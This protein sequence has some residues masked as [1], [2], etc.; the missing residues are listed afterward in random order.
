MC[1]PGKLLGDRG[2]V[3]TSVCWGDAERSHTN[4][5]AGAAEVL[6]CDRDQD[7]ARLGRYKLCSHSRGSGHLGLWRE[8]FGVRSGGCLVF[9]GLSCAAKNA[10]PDWFGFF[11]GQINLLGKS[12][13]FVVWQMEITGSV[14]KWIQLNK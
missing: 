7:M 9:C 1:E 14:S 10:I 12:F 11:P 5:G 8:L 6:C 2:S 13:N 4:P 3:N